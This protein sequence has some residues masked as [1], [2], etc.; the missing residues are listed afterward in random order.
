MLVTYSIFKQSSQEM[1]LFGTFQPH[2]ECIV[3][4]IVFLFIKRSSLYLK[5]GIESLFGPENG[6][7]S[8]H[9]LHEPRTFCEIIRSDRR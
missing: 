3:F 7:W 8:M 5:G 6:G 4:I 2:L 9:D 1:K